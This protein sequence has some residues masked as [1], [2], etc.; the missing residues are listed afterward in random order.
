VLV[1]TGLGEAGR[2][3][4]VDVIDASGR[5]VLTDELDGGTDMLDLSS[6]RSGAYVLRGNGRVARFS[7]N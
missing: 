2:G 1:V 3:V 5:V 6:L 7:R 4:A